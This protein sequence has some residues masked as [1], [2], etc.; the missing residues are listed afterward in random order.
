MPH[1]GAGGTNGGDAS[2]F[3]GIIMILLIGN[4]GL[5]YARFEGTK[6]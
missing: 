3:I 6:A 1:R 4:T 2:F 5:F